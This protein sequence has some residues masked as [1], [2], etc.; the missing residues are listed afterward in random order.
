MKS[1]ITF[2]LSICF[3]F[4]IATTSTSLLECGPPQNVST[5]VINAGNISFDWDDCTDGCSEYLVHYTREEDGY[6]SSEYSTGISAFAFTNLPA[7]N[8]DFY[9]TTV[10]ESGR[11]AA[12]IVE[13][14]IA[15]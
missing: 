6:V 13:E 12:I 1:S 4:F 5:T 9:F 10:C 7:G 11:S 8:Y 2:V 15:N 14:I 3:S